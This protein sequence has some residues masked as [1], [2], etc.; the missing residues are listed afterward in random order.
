[1]VRSILNKS[2][3]PLLVLVVVS[4]GTSKKAYYSNDAKN[5]N[6]DSQSPKGEKIHTLYLIGDTGELDNLDSK[7]N[8]TVDAMVCLL[9]TSPSPRDS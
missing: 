4:C 6:S 3:L 9:Y 7:S 8:Y 1:M 5:W 2:L